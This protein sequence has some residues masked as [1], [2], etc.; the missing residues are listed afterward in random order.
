M[1]TSP[2]L[3]T[4]QCTCTA[5][6]V[7]MKVIQRC[8]RRSTQEMKI[9]A[10]FYSRLSRRNDKNI[11]VDSE[12]HTRG[13]VP[14]SKCSYKYASIQVQQAVQ[15]PVCR[16]LRNAAI[17]WYRLYKIPIELLHCRSVR[18]RARFTKIHKASKDFTN[19]RTCPEIPIAKRVRRQRKKNGSQLPS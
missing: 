1:Q 15:R 13:L 16:L 9:T 8:V 14:Q 19:A 4:R 7:N 17:Q 12:S 5:I 2:L 10:C 3:S 18:Y 11:A 6:T